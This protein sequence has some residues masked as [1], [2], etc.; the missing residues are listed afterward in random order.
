M[1]K[2][3]REIIKDNI[4]KEFESKFSHFRLKFSYDE[5]RDRLTMYTEPKS[6]KDIAQWQSIIF[7]KQNANSPFS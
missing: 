3:R 7:G 2:S 1:N 6:K 4:R 5:K